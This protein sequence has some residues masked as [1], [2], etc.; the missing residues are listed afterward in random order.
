MFY[1]EFGILK[2][3]VYSITS[4]QDIFRTSYELCF[5]LVS[6]EDGIQNQGEEGIDCGGPACADCRKDTKSLCKNEI[7]NFIKG[8]QIYNIS[9]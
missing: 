4:V 1:F 5:F 9:F 7:F 6:C 3:K 2:S 8:C